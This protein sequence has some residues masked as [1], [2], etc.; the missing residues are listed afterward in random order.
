MAFADVLVA[1]GV[2]KGAVKWMTCLLLSP[3]LCWGQDQVDNPVQRHAVAV[4]LG[5]GGCYYCF[6]S[7]ILNLLI[8]SGGVYLIMLLARRRSGILSMVFSMTFLI[9]W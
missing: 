2:P 4:L 5:I 6:G 8:T 3:L 9:Y 7:A 1:A